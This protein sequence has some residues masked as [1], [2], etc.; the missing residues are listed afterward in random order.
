MLG[1]DPVLMNRHK[2]ISSH[3]FTFKWEGIDNKLSKQ[4]RHII[5][6]DSMYHRNKIT[7]ES[8]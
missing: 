6:A 8:A 4:V 3:A 5:L 2:D 7:K 1:T